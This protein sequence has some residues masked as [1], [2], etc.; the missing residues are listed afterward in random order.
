MCLAAPLRRFELPL[1]N[2]NFP[3]I[4]SAIKLKFGSLFERRGGR[5]LQRVIDTV[6]ACVEANNLKVPIF[7][8][9]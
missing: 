6:S 3:N 1:Q 2:L 9:F 8:T 4:F 5:F 7:F